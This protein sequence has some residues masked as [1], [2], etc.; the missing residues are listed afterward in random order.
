[1][2]VPTDTIADYLTRI[3]NA[4]RGLKEKV[5]VPGSKMKIRL[6]E[7]LKEEGYIE[8]FKC[9]EEGPKKAIRIHLKYKKGKP[10]IQ[11]I[12]RCSK[13]G[14]RTYVDHTKIQKVLGGLGLS[15]LST[16]KG[17][18]TGKQARA[19]GIGG[20]LICKVW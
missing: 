13:P 7:I 8:Q 19:E 2:A 6:T 1:M 9:V 15:I 16:S 20:E 5:T 4:A 14:L 12:V 18:I 17:V 10:V 11:H 3:R